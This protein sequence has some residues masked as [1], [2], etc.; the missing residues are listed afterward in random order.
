MS[1]RSND[2]HPNVS[3]TKISQSLQRG[4][5]PQPGDTKGYQPTA[6]TTPLDINNPP[7]DFTAITLVPPPKPSNTAPP[8]PPAEAPAKE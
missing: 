2:T 1:Q 7:S 8:N 4:F 6:S 5:Q 3:K